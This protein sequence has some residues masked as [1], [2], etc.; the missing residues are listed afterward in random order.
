VQVIKQNLQPSLALFYH[1]RGGG[2]LNDKSE[3]LTSSLLANSIKPH[4]ICLTEQNL[5]LIHLENYTLAA[6][7]S[8]INCKG[9][10]ACLFVIIL[11][12]VILVC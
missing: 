5:L 9:G 7:Y 6:N 2:G 4:I 12:C 11:R 1:N 3:E 10:G 8:C